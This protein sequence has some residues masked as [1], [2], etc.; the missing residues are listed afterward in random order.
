MKRV[1]QGMS[2]PILGTVL[3]HAHPRKSSVLAQFP[4]GLAPGRSGPNRRDHRECAR[5]TGGRTVAVMQPYFFPYV[6]YFS[7]IKH[8]DRFILLDPVQFIRR[9]WIN[10]NRILRQGEGWI[11]FHVPLLGH[12]H[13]APIN[14]V[15]VN[16]AEPWKD[17]LLAQIAPYRRISPY[18]AP[19]RELISDAISGDHDAITSLNK[20]VL[21][22]V[23]AYIGFSRELEILSEMNLSFRP[24]AAPDEWPLNICQALGNVD[25]YWNPPGGQSF[26]DRS[27]YQSAGIDLKFQTLETPVYDQRRPAFTPHLSIID[28]LMF[29]APDEV[30]AMLDRYTLT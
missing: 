21:Q 5:M 10:R 4:S 18:Y 7:L 12:A 8:T 19:V 29:N 22:A 13:D 25:S 28:T 3:D 17:K 20:A 27:K 26:Y 16:N 2:V 6:G 24:P 23:C 9:G 15:Q 11:W 30:N 14:T 1:G